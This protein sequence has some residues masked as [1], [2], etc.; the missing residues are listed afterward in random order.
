MPTTPNIHN[1]ISSLNYSICNTNKSDIG[2]ITNHTV[3][4]SSANYGF[5]IGGLVTLSI[6]VVTFLIVKAY[7]CTHPR[8]SNNITSQ[9]ITFSDESDSTLACE[10]RRNYHRYS[11][12]P[13]SIPERVPET[14][15][16]EADVNEILQ[17]VT[18]K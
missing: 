6:I 9:T 14:K 3:T 11:Y 12:F 15:F 5:L 4:I 13:E 18:T 16:T 10:E 1:N 8:N 17:K 7:K 2:K